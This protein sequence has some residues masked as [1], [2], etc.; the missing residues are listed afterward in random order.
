MFNEI[1][2]KNFAF[3][4]ALNL[5][6]QRKLKLLEALVEAQA[7]DV[8]SS[9]SFLGLTLSALD[10]GYLHSLT[11]RMSCANNEYDVISTWVTNVTFSP[12]KRVFIFV[13]FD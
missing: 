4:N 8:V 1:P 12:R 10:L 9:H 2:E 5:A 11:I 13:I 6:I 3:W 7:L